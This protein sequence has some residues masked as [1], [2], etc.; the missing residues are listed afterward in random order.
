MKGEMR[1]RPSI[2]LTVPGSLR[3]RQVAVRVVAEA[4]RMVS[5]GT[6]EPPVNGADG[7]DLRNP[8]DSAFVSAF[9]EIFNNIAIHAYQRTATGAIELIITIG[10]DYLE[11]EIRD[12][13]VAFDLDAVAPLALD[14]LHEGGMGIHIARTML[15]ELH[16]EA[17]PPNL[18]RLRKAL[19]VASA[20]DTPSGSTLTMS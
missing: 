2:Q 17:G 9:A 20:S 14:E 4:A 12:D 15:D 16:Y 10:E 18:W 1:G 8:F 19:P 3:Y 7:Y 5:E 13:G 11:V 6:S